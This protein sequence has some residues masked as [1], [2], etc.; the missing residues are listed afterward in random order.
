VG[1]GASRR[2][3]AIALVILVVIIGLIVGLVVGLREKTN[4][5]YVF[6]PSAVFDLA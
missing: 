3:Y 6:V 4:A 5:K 2:A 1:G